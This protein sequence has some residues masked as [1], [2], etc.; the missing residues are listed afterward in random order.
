MFNIQTEDTFNLIVDTYSDMIFRIAYQNLYNISDAE[1][2]VQDVYVKL[3]KNK[4]IKFNDMEHLKAWL[5]KVTINQCLD[6]KK[7]FF[8]KNVVPIE[9]QIIPYEDEELFV[10]E[11]IKKLSEEERN[12]IYLYYYEGYNIREI[13]DLLNRKQNTINSKLTRARRKL[14]KIILEGGY[15]S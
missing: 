11:E 14:K 15:E 9:E 2:V 10:L 13:S 6:Y 8:R 1:D 12:I 3:L 4:H 5:I 7:S